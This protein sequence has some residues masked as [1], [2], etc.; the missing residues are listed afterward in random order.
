[1]IILLLC[2]AVA[3][4]NDHHHHFSCCTELFYRVVVAAIVLTVNSDFP[5]SCFP[6]ES[7]VVGLAAQ[8]GT[9][10]VTSSDCLQ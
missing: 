3:R 5:R 1:M 10:Q 2:T 4:N 8:T 6:A 9:S 7:C